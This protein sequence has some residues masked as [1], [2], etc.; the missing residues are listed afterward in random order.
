MEFVDGRERD[1]LERLGRGRLDLALTL[2]RPGELRFPGEPLLTE[3][4]ALAM[5]EHHSLGGRIAI[6]AE[7][8]AGEVMIVRRH[9][10][11]LAETSRHFTQ[12]GVRPFFAARTYDEERAM[13]LVQAG[14]AMTVMPDSYAAP[15]VARPRLRGF[16]LERTVGILYDSSEMRGEVAGSPIAEALRAAVRVRPAV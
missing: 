4:Y 2:V 1:L 16:Q 9:C 7:E 15:G 6:D 8:L 14:V 3:G 13:M 12:R 11:A 10:E 5:S